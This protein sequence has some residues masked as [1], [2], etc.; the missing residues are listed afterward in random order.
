MIVM[1]N[2]VTQ[3]EEIVMLIGLMKEEMIVMI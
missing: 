2:G 3:D 1:N